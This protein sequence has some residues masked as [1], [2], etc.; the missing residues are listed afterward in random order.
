MKSLI[1]RWGVRLLGTLVAIF[2]VCFGVAQCQQAVTEDVPDTQYPKPPDISW[3]FTPWTNNDQL[4]LKTRREIDALASSGKLTK[5]KWAEFYTAA[6]RDKTTPLVQFRWAY[7]TYKAINLAMPFDNQSNLTY[8]ITLRLE[9]VALPSSYEWTRLRYLILMTHDPKKAYRAVAERLMKRNSRDFPVRYFYIYT[10]DIVSP[11]ALRE[12]QHIVK[13]WPKKPS[14]YLLLGRVNRTRWTSTS[15]RKDF[16]NAI[17]AYKKAA[18]LA[19]KGSLSQRQAEGSIKQMIRIRNK[20]K[21][22]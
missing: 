13:L 22:P 6:L 12:A 20:Y 4:L 15:G 8:Q 2:V 10:F 19:P 1:Y 14:A 21:M 9:Q 18:Q 3:G 17:A 16:D 11:E 7:A 5:T